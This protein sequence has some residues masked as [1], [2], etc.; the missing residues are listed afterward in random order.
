[1]IS[2]AKKVVSYKGKDGSNREYSDFVLN[3]GDKH[4]L[5]KP[6]F[7]SDYTTLSLLCELLKGASK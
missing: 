5:I 2:L 4:I 3:V 7:K 1:M 6:V